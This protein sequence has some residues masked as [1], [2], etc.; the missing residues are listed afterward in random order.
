MISILSALLLPLLKGK[1]LLKVETWKNAQLVTGLLAA[2][3]T[4]IL[5][6]DPSWAK[7]SPLVQPM[8]EGIALIGSAL[9][10][11]WT[12]STTEKIGLP[13][14]E[15]DVVVD[16]AATTDGLPNFQSGGDGSNQ[17]LP[18]ENS[19]NSGAKGLLGGK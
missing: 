16:D 11:Y 13:S 7:F 9:V 14:K 15:A 3:A 12:V 10:M 19:T 1:A 6:I 17:P 2:I 18:T 4:G 5:A 8:C